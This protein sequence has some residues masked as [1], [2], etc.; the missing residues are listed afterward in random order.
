VGGTT[1]DSRYVDQTDAEGRIAVRLKMGPTAAVTGV[2]ATLF[3]VSINETVPVT[4]KAGAAARFVFAPADTAVRVGASYA[5]GAAV[6]DRHGNPRPDA[7]TLVAA[8]GRASVAGSTV[9]GVAVGRGVVVAHSGAIADT[10]RVSV[11]PP[12][13]LAVF[14]ASSLPAD[15]ASLL[16]VATDGSQRHRVVRSHDYF[17][18]VE[19]VPA[20]SADGARLVFSDVP[21]INTTRPQLWV[22]DLVNAPV[23]LP[24]G[25]WYGE[26][27]P[28]YSANG[29][30]IYYSVRAGPPD[31]VVWRVHPDGTGAEEVVGPSTSY[32]PPQPSTS[33]DGTQ[34]LYSLSLAGGLQIKD[35]GTRAT[36]L[37][38]GSGFVGRWSPVGGTIA[39]IPLPSGGIWTINADGTG[40][41]A[42][43]PPG[44]RYEGGVQ[45]SPDG[46]YVISRESNS[47]LL[48]IVD[49]ATGEAIPLPFSRQMRRPAWKP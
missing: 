14:L 8:N 12:G 49:V 42:V 37:L 34:L 23:A 3:G 26:F 25:P 38:D 30:W 28:S 9:T 27:E 2:K 33:P 18:S 40:A 32:A 44:H 39:Y 48:E 16:T 36:R 45:W 21:N 5:L 20:W 7:F 1:F 11:V 41:H 4:V 35:L 24:P 47:G 6:A 17:G 29:Q 19:M 10:A 22:S 46:K 43:S 31:W 13:T 15:S